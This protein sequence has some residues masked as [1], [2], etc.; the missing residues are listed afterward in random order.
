MVFSNYKTH[1]AQLENKPIKKLKFLKHSAPRKRSCGASLKKCRYCGKSRGHVSQ[2]GIN[3]C[4]QC[5]REHATEIGFK[6][7]S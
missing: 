2:Y 1:M 5:F 3:F 7:Y 4:R 6:R